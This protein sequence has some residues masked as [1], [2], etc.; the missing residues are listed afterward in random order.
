MN[1]NDN[2]TSNNT[3]NNG[4]QGIEAEAFLDT[5]KKADLLFPATFLKLELV[6]ISGRFPSSFSSSSKHM[7]E[8][9]RMEYP[10]KPISKTLIPPKRK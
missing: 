1:T 10:V 7:T 5:L 4:D 6:E 2:N 9:Y 3:C 8:K